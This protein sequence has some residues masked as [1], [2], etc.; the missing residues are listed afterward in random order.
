MPGYSRFTSTGQWT[1]RIPSTYDGFVSVQNLT[2]PE[3]VIR[4]HTVGPEGSID[5]D[6]AGYGDYLEVPLR[7]V[8]E[9]TMYALDDP[10]AGVFTAGLLFT[11]Q[12]VRYGLRKNGWIGALAKASNVGGAPGSTAYAAPGG[13]SYTA[14]TGSSNFPVING[15]AEPLNNGT[16]RRVVV[17]GSG[18]GIRQ[19]STKWQLGMVGNY[20][21]IS[22]WVSNASGIRT[23]A[24]VISDAGEGPWK[25]DLGAC[26]FDAGSAGGWRLNNATDGYGDGPYWGRDFGWSNGYWFH[27]F[28][29]SATYPVDTDEYTVTVSLT[30]DL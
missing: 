27:T 18:S 1:P 17:S 6:C 21:E 28:F 12:R 5:F 15:L 9:F 29:G 26:T 22:P 13:I 7:L 20:D 4:V 25:V 23:P 10:D 16:I 11:S 2:W 3:R 14:R 30:R 19:G 24:V 8:V